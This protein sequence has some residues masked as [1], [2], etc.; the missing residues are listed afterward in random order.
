M[1]DQDIISTTAACFHAATAGD[2]CD[3]TRFGGDGIKMNAS[4]ENRHVAYKLK[5]FA[6]LLGVSEITVRRWIKLGKVKRMGGIRHI[7]IP[8][9][10]LDR[11][12]KEG[13]S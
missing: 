9:F 3:A 7:V 6:D 10:E 5:K 8:A 4:D 2:G 13:V 12:L 1:T 11:I